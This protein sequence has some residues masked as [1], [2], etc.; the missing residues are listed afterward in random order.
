MRSRGVSDCGVKKT[1]LINIRRLNFIQN[2]KYTCYMPKTMNNSRNSTKSGYSMLHILLI[3][4]LSMAIISLMCATALTGGARPILQVQYNFRDIIYSYN[5]QKEEDALQEEELEFSNVASFPEIKGQGVTNGYVEQFSESFIFVAGYPDGSSRNFTEALLNRFDV[6]Y[7]DLDEKY[8]IRAPAAFIELSLWLLKTDFQL[9]ESNLSKPNLRDNRRYPDIYFPYFDVER[10]K[11]HPDFNGY[12]L[13]KAQELAVYFKEEL[14]K[15]VVIEFPW[16]GHILPVWQE[17]F[18]WGEDAVSVYFPEYR[19]INRQLS[20]ALGFQSY[21]WFLS[22]EET[23]NLLNFYRTKLVENCDRFCTVNE[24]FSTPRDKH[25]SLSMEEFEK[26]S[27]T[28]QKQY[29]IFAE[30]A[31]VR[32]AD[33]LSVLPPLQKNSREA[34]ATIVT[35]TDTDYVLSALV[36]GLSLSIQDSSRDRIALLTEDA[37]GKEMDEVFEQFGWIVKRITSVPEYWFNSPDC[38]YRP[39]GMNQNTR[40][41]RMSSKLRLFQLT[42]Y[43]KVL[44]LDTDVIVTGDVTQLFKKNAAF[45]PEANDS[46][47]QLIGE[48]GV[49]HRYVNAGALLLK[50]AQDTFDSFIQYAKE[51]PPPGLFPNLVDCTEQS[52][53]NAF[54]LSKLEENQNVKDGLGNGPVPITLK[55][56]GFQDPRFHIGRLES[57]GSCDICFAH[58]DVRRDYTMHKPLAVHFVRVDLCP[59]PWRFVKALK[60]A[61]QEMKYKKVQDSLFTQNIY[62]SISETKRQLYSEGFMNQ[63]SLNERQ[64]QEL[65]ALLVTQ[66][67]TRDAL[68]SRGIVRS[69]R[70]CSHEPYEY[71]N[72]ILFASGRV[73]DEAS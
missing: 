29:S 71:W 53:F 19:D 3:T 34:Y 40:W 58:P 17:I 39:K 51:N 72:I 68:D 26:A 1:D 60:K 65:E 13:P 20:N 38:K 16:I 69:W 48:G 22:A 8:G 32:S 36:L 9:E 67:F 54:Y 62:E 49:G 59:K 47:L 43:D 63:D 10:I 66:N 21:N 25:Q 35:S 5:S 44:Y 64:T 57:T 37:P 73:M 2:L 46:A 55:P 15:T 24:V 23:F 56:N 31:K 12:F 27:S 11:S 50:P 30:F 41:G 14:K 45:D 52:L 70:V 4:L 28:R 6:T 42:D 18:E 7:F 61:E 33:P